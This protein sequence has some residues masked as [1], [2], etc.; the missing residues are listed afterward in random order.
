MDVRGRG[1]SGH[2]QVAPSRRPKSGTTIG[3]EDTEIHV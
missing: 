2:N 1:T 3:V